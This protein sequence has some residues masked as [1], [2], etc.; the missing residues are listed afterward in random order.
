M[1]LFSCRLRL[2]CT[3][4]VA[5]CVTMSEPGHAHTASLT[6]GMETLS[7]HL[8]STQKSRLGRSLF[9]MARKDKALTPKATPSQLRKNNSSARSKGLAG[10]RKKARKSQRARSQRTITRDLS[11]HGILEKPR[12]YDPIPSQQNGAVPNPKV[13]DVRADHFQE[14]DKNQDGVLDPLERATSRLDID[15]DV[16]NREWK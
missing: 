11:Y 2:L 6:S 7:H 5:A 14:L 8:N 9:L 12:R 15:R 1:T 10:V 4:I 16:S 13:R 3:L